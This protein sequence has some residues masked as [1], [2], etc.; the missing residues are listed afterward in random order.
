MNGT[1]PPAAAVSLL[2]GGPPREAQP[3]IDHVSALVRTLEG[4]R[5]DR[6]RGILAV[7]LAEVAGRLGND[8]GAKRLASAFGF[9]P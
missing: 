9:K 4:Q 3:L 7:K 8:E 1:S 6:S 2:A 5:S